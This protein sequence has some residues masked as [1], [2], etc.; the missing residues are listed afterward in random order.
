MK[1]CRTCQK[2]YTDLTLNFCLDDGTPLT[3]DHHFDPEAETLKVGSGYDTTPISPHP[4]VGLEL[5][6][7]LEGKGK[8]VFRDKQFAGTR[9]EGRGLEGFQIRL[10]PPV[11]GLSLKYMAH[12]EGATVTLGQTTVTDPRGVVRMPRTG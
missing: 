11:Q 3:S 1:H 10:D 6:V 12:L 2:T 5:T 9:H 7:Q 4:A 8:R